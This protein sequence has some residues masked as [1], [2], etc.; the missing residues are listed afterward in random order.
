MPTYTHKIYLKKKEETKG[1]SQT[2]L[3]DSSRGF[4]TGAGLASSFSA[5]PSSDGVF[6]RVAGFP[7]LP[8]IVVVFG[9]PTQRW[10]VSSPR[11]Q[12][13]RS[14]GLASS[15]SAL[16]SSDGGWF[17][18]SPHSQPPV[19]RRCLRRSHPTVGWFVSSPRSQPTRSSGLASSSSVLP[20]S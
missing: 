2:G 13:T 4:P 17:V 20:S 11:S 16:P 8:L 15:S 10:F 5:L 9:A 6:L 19:G 12:P 7:T 18:S 3:L 1:Q 14:L